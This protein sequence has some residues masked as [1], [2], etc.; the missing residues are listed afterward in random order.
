MMLSQQEDLTVLGQVYD[1]REALRQVQLLSPDVVLLDFNMPHLD[2]LELTR[3]LT[4]HFA[5]IRI[6]ILSMYS[7]QRYVNDFRQAGAK[8]YLLKTAS[9]EEVTGAI[10]AIAAGGERFLTNPATN[11][12][13]EDD[14]LKR[15]RLS[16]REVDIVRCVRQG[17]SSP[18]IAEQLHISSHTA[19]T[20]RRNILLKLGLHN[21]QD[22]VRFACEHGI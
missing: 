5:G 3:Q 11:N 12:H 18:Q 9:S 13:S 16:P 19:N 1:P 6:L 14:F 7:E 20:H 8:G 4:A 21:V 2:G 22:L 15:F 10:R 17:L